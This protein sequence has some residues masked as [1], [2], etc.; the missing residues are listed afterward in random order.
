MYPLYWHSIV[1]II[2]QLE[3]EYNFDQWVENYQ[4]NCISKYYQLQQVSNE[5]NNYFTIWLKVIKHYFSN[6]NM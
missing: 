6:L 4:D 2:S 1:S 3:I 5:I